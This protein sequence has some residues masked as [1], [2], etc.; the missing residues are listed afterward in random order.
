MRAKQRCTSLS[1]SFICM[2]H[3]MCMCV[4]PPGSLL[5]LFL[6]FCFAIILPIGHVETERWHMVFSFSKRIFCI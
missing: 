6:F 1:V 2:V 4:K 5:L 3:A